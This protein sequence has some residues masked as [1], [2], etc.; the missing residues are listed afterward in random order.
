MQLTLEMW[1]E[2]TEMQTTTME[3]YLTLSLKY[4]EMLFISLFKWK[5]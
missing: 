2:I 5:T 4:I 1:I 3:N